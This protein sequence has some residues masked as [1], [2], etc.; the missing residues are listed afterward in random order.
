MKALSRRS[1]LLGLAGFAACLALL[2]LA[3]AAVHGTSQTSFCLSCHEMR[4]T[5]HELDASTH[6]RNRSGYRTQCADCHIAPGLGGM[7]AAKWKGLGELRVHLTEPGRLAGEQWAARRGELKKRLLHEMPQANCTRCHDVM[8]MKPSTRDAE[9]AHKTITPRMRCLD[10]HSVE[11]L[12][13]VV[14][15]ARE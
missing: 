8:S 9:V 12:E 13:F 4:D 3:W 7:I 5:G 1:V 15:N 11:G 10:C 14:H 2:S 6:G